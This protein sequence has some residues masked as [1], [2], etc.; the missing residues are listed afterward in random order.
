MKERARYVMPSGDGK[1]Y[2]VLEHPREL[3]ARDA[4]LLVM[5]L[6]LIIRH[7]RMFVADPAPKEEEPPRSQ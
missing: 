3:S 1:D 7:C 2:F 5:W 4:E 6:E